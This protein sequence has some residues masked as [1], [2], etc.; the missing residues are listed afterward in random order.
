[1]ST[2]ITSLAIAE[3]FEKI[4]EVKITLNSLNRKL[5]GED[6]EIAAKCYN[7]FYELLQNP[8][9]VHISNIDL[10]RYKKDVSGLGFA[11]SS[12]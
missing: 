3:Y 11:L 9:S 6:Y 8:L 1:M 2:Q 10:M 4:E 5:Q 12:T 7:S